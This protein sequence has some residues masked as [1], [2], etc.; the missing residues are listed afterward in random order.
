M[1]LLIYIGFLFCQWL[2]LL[3]TAQRSVFLGNGE[4]L[5]SWHLIAIESMALY[6]ALDTGVM[7]DLGSQGTA[8]S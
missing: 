2:S 3:I 7:A 8:Q 1:Q 4:R 6:L 5:S